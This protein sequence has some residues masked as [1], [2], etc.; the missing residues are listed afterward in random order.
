[1]FERSHGPG[2][3]FWCGR[4]RRPGDGLIGNGI[5]R[6]GFD[7]V[8]KIIGGD[9]DGPEVIGIEGH[10]NGLTDELRWGLIE[11]ALEGKGAVGFD[12]SGNPG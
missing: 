10:V 6:I 4:G 11:M 7:K 5:E 2:F 8:G 1:M 3:R 9:P 12:A